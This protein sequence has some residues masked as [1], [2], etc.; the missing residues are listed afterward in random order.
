M[1]ETN[2]QLLSEVRQPLPSLQSQAQCIDYEFQREGVADLFMFFE[3]LIVKRFIEV[4]AQRTRKD[5]VYAMKSLAD[6]IY[7]QVE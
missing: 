4:R 3:P 7:P 2:K 6:E 5:W 1:D